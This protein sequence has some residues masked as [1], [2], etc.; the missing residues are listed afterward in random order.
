M[1]TSSNNNFSR[2]CRTQDFWDDSAAELS[3]KVKGLF[4]FFGAEG[5]SEA[6]TMDTQQGC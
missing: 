4:F 6:R 2:I 3:K 1:C 5:E